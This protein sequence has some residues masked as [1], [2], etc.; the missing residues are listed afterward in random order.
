MSLQESQYLFSGGR[1]ES[2]NVNPCWNPGTNLWTQ[3]LDNYFIIYTRCIYVVSKSLHM[4]LY[5]NSSTILCYYFYLIHRC[6]K[7]VPPVW[8]QM[9]VDISEFVSAYVIGFYSPY[10]V[11]LPWRHQSL[12]DELSTVEPNVLLSLTLKATSFDSKFL[13]SFLITAILLSTSLYMISQGILSLCSFYGK[14]YMHFMKSLTSSAMIKLHRSS[15]YWVWLC[16]F[17][18]IS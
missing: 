3:S 12:N 18:M 9:T 14:P 2:K 17:L 4:W 5:L 15:K 1:L 16:S 6:E 11:G 8:C 7:I 10:S 13:V